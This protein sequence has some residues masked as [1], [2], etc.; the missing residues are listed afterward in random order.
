LSFGAVFMGLL[1]T[2]NPFSFLAKFAS[3]LREVV[4]KLFA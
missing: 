2:T 4:I 1:S 3:S